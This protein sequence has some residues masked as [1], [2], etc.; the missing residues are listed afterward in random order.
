M[1]WPGRTATAIAAADRLRRL[2][3]VAGRSQQLRLPRAHQRIGFDDLLPPAPDHGRSGIGTAAASFFAAVRAE[4]VPEVFDTRGPE[5]HGAEPADIGSV[6]SDVRFPEPFDAGF[7]AFEPPVRIPEPIPADP[8]YWRISLRG[9]MLRAGTRRVATSLRASNA[10]RSVPSR[11]AGSW[12]RRWRW[13]GGAR[14][15]R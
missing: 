10:A 5:L 1:V 13:A 7:S 6:M 4:P 11:P 2:G 8:V 14:S 3:P 12:W 9:Q 15:S